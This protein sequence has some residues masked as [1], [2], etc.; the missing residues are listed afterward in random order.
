MSYTPRNPGLHNL[1]ALPSVLPLPTPYVERAYPMADDSP[2]TG[3]CYCS[4]DCVRGEP[5]DTCDCT[6][7]HDAEWLT[8]T[9]VQR[10]YCMDHAA[11]RHRLL[12]R[13]GCP[14]AEC[15]E[16][17]ARNPYVNGHR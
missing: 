9:P 4:A 17:I 16:R 8:M 13:S 15:A 1:S 14:M 5:G 12:A 11:G 6:E 7:C 2:A 10:M 3:E